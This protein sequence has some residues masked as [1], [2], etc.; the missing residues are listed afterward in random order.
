MDM[1]R[2]R[3]DFRLD[4]ELLARLDAEA[5]RLGQTRTKY[6]ERALES[7]LGDVVGQSTNPPGGAS[8]APTRAPLPPGVRSARELAMERQRKMNE[9]KS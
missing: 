5:E 6:V 4:E 2:R 9:R 7:A 8:P 1:A 3:V